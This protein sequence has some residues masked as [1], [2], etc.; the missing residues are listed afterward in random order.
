MVGIYI[1]I[2]TSHFLRLA[3]KPLLSN[4]NPKKKISF[5][6]KGILLQIKSLLYSQ[7]WLNTLARWTLCNWTPM[8]LTIMSSIYTFNKSLIPPS[9]VLFIIFFGMSNL[10]FSNQRAW[11]CIYNFHAPSW[12]LYSLYLLHAWEFDC[13]WNKRMWMTLTCILLNYLQTY[14]CW[15]R[16]MNL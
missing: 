7:T 15:I 10:P 14:Q 16:G 12:R 1:L 6:T 11:R 2:I 3:L 9:K 5:D 8:D 4:K 13:L